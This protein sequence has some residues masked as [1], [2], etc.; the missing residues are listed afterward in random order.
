MYYRVNTRVFFLMPTI[1]VGI[2]MDGR[3]FVEAAWFCFVLGFGE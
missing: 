2:D 3:Y 1:A